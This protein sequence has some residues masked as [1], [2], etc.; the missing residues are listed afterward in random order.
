MSEDRRVE[1]KNKGETPEEE[2]RPTEELQ[3]EE[4]E[5]PKF[6]IPWTALIIFGVLVVLAAVCIIVIYSLGGPI[7]TK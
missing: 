5:K 3:E 2:F 1:E 7:N 4:I 6:E